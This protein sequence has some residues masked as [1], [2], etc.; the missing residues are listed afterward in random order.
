MPRGSSKRRKALEKRPHGSRCF[1]TIPCNSDKEEYFLVGENYVSPP[2]TITIDKPYQVEEVSIYGDHCMQFEEFADALGEDGDNDFHSEN[3]ELTEEDYDVIEGDLDS[4]DEFEV[5]EEVLM[6]IHTEIEA[7]EILKKQKSAECEEWARL[8]SMEGKDVKCKEYQ[9]KHTGQRG[10]SL[11]TNYRHKKDL[12]DLEKV[13][14][15]NNNSL[16]QCWSGCPSFCS[17]KEMDYCVDIKKDVEDSVESEVNEES[18][19]R[20]HDPKI[21]YQKAIEFLNENGAKIIKNKRE[22]GKRNKTTSSYQ[23]VQYIAVARYLQLLLEGN[24]KMEASDEVARM[25]FA[26]KF[27]K[28]KHKSTKGSYMSRCIRNWADNILDEGCVK[29]PRQGK[30]IRIL[31]VLTSKEIQT[32]LIS[33]LK[34]TPVINR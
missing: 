3:D 24:G 10:D 31:N 20:T 33:H 21:G 17:K 4:D 27:S 14:A 12:A 22:E 16:Y 11:R 26:E 23:H 8:I 34:N 19:Y 29:D 32:R 2:K 25:L 5:D 7:N 28:G 30:H 1:T 18:A 9:R 15:M 13:G 6:S